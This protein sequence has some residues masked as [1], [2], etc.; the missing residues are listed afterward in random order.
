MA[1]AGQAAVPLHY[2]FLLLLFDAMAVKKVRDSV[3]RK[4]KQAKALVKT[5]P[6]KKKKKKK[7]EKEEDFLSSFFSPHFFSGDGKQGVCFLT[8]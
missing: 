1:I 7:K 6:K 2:F 5:C 4:S 3:R 8:L